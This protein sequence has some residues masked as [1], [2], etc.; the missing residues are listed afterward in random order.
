MKYKSLIAGKKD[1]HFF[2]SD[3]DVIQ[4]AVPARRLVSNLST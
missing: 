3:F 4:L 2:V 1:V